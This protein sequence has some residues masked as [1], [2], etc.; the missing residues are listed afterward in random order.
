MQPVRLLERILRGD[1]ANVDFADAQRLIEPLG[2]EQLRVTGSHHV[3]ARLGIPEQLSL[4]T[5][6]GHAKPYQ[7][8]QLGR[9]VPAPSARAL[10]A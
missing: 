9:P 5:R 1:V 10:H 3:Y 6:H 4:Q 2:F 7:P 8:R